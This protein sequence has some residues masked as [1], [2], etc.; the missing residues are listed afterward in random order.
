MSEKEIAETILQQLGGNQFCMMIGAKKPL[1]AL[2]SNLERL[3]GISIGFKAR[4][5]RGIKCVKIELMPSDTYRVSFYGPAPK[6]SCIESRDNVYCDELQSLF[7]EVTCLATHLFGAV[8]F[9]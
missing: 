2:G 4:A 1:V 8:N 9:G 5:A 6:F 7:E 3:G